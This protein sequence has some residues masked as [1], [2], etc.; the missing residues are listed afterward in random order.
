MIRGVE[1]V[2]RRRGCSGREKMFSVIIKLNSWKTFSLFSISYLLRRAAR[3]TIKNLVV[4]MVL[5][6]TKKSLTA[7]ELTPRRKRP[8]MA[9]LHSYL[10]LLVRGEEQELPRGKTISP[11]P[12]NHNPKILFF[13]AMDGWTRGPFRVL[14]FL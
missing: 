1:K 4:K 14:R 6:L 5:F 2:Q 11:C 9:A 12:A 3:K 13:Q 8:K 7:T 10:H